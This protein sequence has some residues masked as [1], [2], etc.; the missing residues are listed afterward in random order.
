MNVNKLLGNVSLFLVISVAV[1]SATSKVP[2]PSFL[3]TIYTV[4]GIMFSI[5]MGVLCT[6]NPDK[7]K[8]DSI[9]KAIKS[10]ILD[11]RNSYL[12][13]FFIISFIYLIY[14]IY[15]DLNYVKVIWK[16][17]ITLDLAC[18]TLFLNILGIL[19]FI[20]NFIQIQ[21]LGMD[22]SDRVRESD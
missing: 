4:S 6:L 11:V 22:I 15:P 20:S 12:A 9:Y 3:N 19:Y 1:A 21:K 14:Q 5:G 7:V 10:N 16:I 2:N 18:A 17:K 13:Y 8:N